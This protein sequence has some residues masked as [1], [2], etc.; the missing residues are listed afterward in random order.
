M[1]CQGA[2]PSSLPGAGLRDRGRRTVTWIKLGLVCDLIV[3]ESQSP[4]RQFVR[5]YNWKTHA[6]PGVVSKVWECVTARL[7]ARTQCG[8]N[9]IWNG[10]DKTPCGWICRECLAMS[11]NPCK[12]ALPHGEAVTS[13]VKCIVTAWCDMGP[14]DIV[15]RCRMVWHDAVLSCV[16]M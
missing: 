11:W 9:C 1:T 12:A 4:V 5:N 14:L 3:T 6:L 8:L 2:P 16:C 10:V 13:Q 15:L 7:I